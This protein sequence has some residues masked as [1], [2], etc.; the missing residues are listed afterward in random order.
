MFRAVLVAKMA[1][2]YHCGSNVAK[3][4][5]HGAV[6]VAQ[7]VAHLTTDREVLGSIPAESW[8]FFLLSILS[9]RRP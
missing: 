8:A 5:M 3:Y 2:Q 4:L 1:E 6:V 9:D 7:V